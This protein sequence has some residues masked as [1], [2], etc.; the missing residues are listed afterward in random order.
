MS[1]YFK[2][3]EDNLLC[4]HCDEDGIDD[5]FLEWLDGVRAEC[6]FSFYVTSAYR[7]KDHPI[8]KRKKGGPGAHSTGKAI[9]ISVR[10]T[11]ALK[12]IEVAIKHGCTRVGVNQK[13]SARFIHLDRSDLPD[14][15]WSY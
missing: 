2:R 3:T 15:L 9:D 13:G 5:E 12:V 4:Q 8:E 7:C 6:G 10:G 11:K 1:K 14:A